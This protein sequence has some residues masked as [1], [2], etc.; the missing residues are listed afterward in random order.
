[1]PVSASKL[2]TAPGSC[3]HWPQAQAVSAGRT[4]RPDIH[5]SRFI[6]SHTYLQGCNMG[7]ALR[8]TRLRVLPWQR[9]FFHLLSRHSPCTAKGKLLRDS[10]MLAHKWHVIQTL[11]LHCSVSLMGQLSKETQKSAEH[12][13][14]SQC[15]AVK[16]RQRDSSAHSLYCYIIILLSCDRA[17]R[18]LPWLAWISQCPLE[19]HGSSS[20]PHTN[21]FDLLPCSLH[22]WHSHPQLLWNTALSFSSFS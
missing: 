8:V 4:A 18:G 15:M 5:I 13:V 1:M 2:H 9:V 20:A 21:I 16:C 3:A 22:T 12:D 19:H 7:T 14:D 10:T 6:A 11:S 17:D